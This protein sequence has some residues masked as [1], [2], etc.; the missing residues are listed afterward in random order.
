MENNN[1]QVPQYPTIP[2]GNQNGYT[3][4]RKVREKKKIDFS[5]SDYIYLF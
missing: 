4:V 1:N 5:V 2:Y 3:Q